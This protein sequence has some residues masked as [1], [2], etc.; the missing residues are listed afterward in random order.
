MIDRELLEQARA[1][2]M[3]EH[4]CHTLIL[5]GSYAAGEQTPASD[6]DM[7][8]VR[9]R[10][11]HCRVGRKINGVFLDAWVYSEDNVPEPESLLY[12][13]GGVVLFEKGEYG[14]RLLAAVRDLAVEPPPPL[15]PW[16]RDFHC[17]WLEKML[18][19]SVSGDA[20][21]DYRRHWLL[22]DLL[23]TWFRFGQIRYPGSKK[24]FQW[25][26]GHRPEVYARFRKA[27]APGAPHEEIRLLV[28]T[29]TGREL[30]GG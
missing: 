2:L 25:L 7:F 10:G 8:A 17:L 22:T 23:E 29:V 24:A 16:E 21:G 28:E 19:R 11:E 3:E 12:L 14:S 9:E 18:I 6:L 15:L 20:E 5:H 1:V 27:L 30:P 4:R 26:E 13:H